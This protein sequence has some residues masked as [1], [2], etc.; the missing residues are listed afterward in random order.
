MKAKLTCRIV[1][2]PED[3]PELLNELETFQPR[4]LKSVRV[5]TF[6]PPMLTKVP[7]GIIMFDTTHLPNNT[8][9]TL[10]VE[11]AGGQQGH[12]KGSAVVICDTDGKPLR[13]VYV[14]TNKIDTN[15]IHAYFVSEKPIIVVRMNFDG[16]AFRLELS[17]HQI[18]REGPVAWLNPQPIFASEN[19]V[20]WFCPHCGGSFLRN[21]EHKSPRGTVCENDLVCKTALPI[22][23]KKFKKVVVASAIKATCLNCRHAHFSADLTK[24]S[25]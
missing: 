2:N 16:S 12:G 4:W 18:W 9:L 20:S 14:P 5:I 7:G 19:A 11:E 6:T 17:E 24:I 10:N 15:G 3:A 25:G 1:V 22:S 8:R 23:L 21:C 13:P